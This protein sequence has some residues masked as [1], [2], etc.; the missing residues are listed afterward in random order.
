VQKA[1]CDG[2]KSVHLV[3]VFAST[4]VHE[5]Q[6]VAGGIVGFEMA[7]WP[8]LVKSSAYVHALLPTT[9]DAIL[10]AFGGQIW[11]SCVGVNAVCE[12][13][14]LAHWSF[15]QISVSTHGTGV[16][17]QDPVVTL[18][19]YVLQLSFAGHC[20]LG[21]TLQYRW[22]AV[23]LPLQSALLVASVILLHA[24]A[25]LTHDVVVHAVSAGQDGPT[26]HAH[27][28]VVELV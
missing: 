1:C 12:H 22:F 13:T 19:A 25:V 2:T 21:C 18:Q 24:A 26:E 6:L 11:F 3:G 17:T 9:H 15:V 20:T 28:R 14:L 7:H 10:Q 5:K 27:A 16:A 4:H 23:M 8:Q